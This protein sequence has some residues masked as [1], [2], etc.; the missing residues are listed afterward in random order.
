[1]VVLWAKSSVTNQGGG[2]HYHQ[3]HGCTF[4]QD[5]S[6]CI[7]TEFGSQQW[8]YTII[9][10]ASR[11]FDDG[12]MTRHSRPLQ[13]APLQAGR[14]RAATDCY[15]PSNQGWS[16]YGN[17]LGFMGLDLKATSKRGL[18]WK[19]IRGRDQIERKGNNRLV[20]SRFYLQKDLGQQSQTGLLK[21]S[22]Y[23]DVD[24][25]TLLVSLGTRDRG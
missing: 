8:I 21:R 16:C 13:H 12:P 9:I 1:M 18:V 6:T 17:T 14:L 23:V 5:C 15:V 4:A 20:K 2:Q 11:R 3:T 22:R 25:N 10:L 7:D 19:L 24:T